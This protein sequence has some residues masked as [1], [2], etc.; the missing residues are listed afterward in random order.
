MTNRKILPVST[1]ERAP[2][3]KTAVNGAVQG[4]SPDTWCRRGGAAGGSPDGRQGGRGLPAPAA[5]TTAR[6]PPRS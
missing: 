5:P 3:A 2:A 1:P 6:P 4:R